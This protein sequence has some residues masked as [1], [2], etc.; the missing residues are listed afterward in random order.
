VVK[1]RGGGGRFM[2]ARH[3]IQ[4]L[5]PI[6]DAVLIEE[7]AAH[8]ETAVALARQIMRRASRIVLNADP[9]GPYELRTDATIVRCPD[10]YIDKRGIKTW[11]TVLSLLAQYQQRQEIAHVNQA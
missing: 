7:S 8:I 11:E 2:M 10:R 3:G 6:H 1:S 4:L 5:G 9:N